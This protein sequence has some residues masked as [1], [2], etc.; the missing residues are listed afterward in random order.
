MVYELSRTPH[1][2]QAV[3]DEIDAI[4]GV[5]VARDPSAICERL[6]S[7][8]GGECISQMIYV[9]AVIKETLRLHPPAGT[10]RMASRGEGL[11]VSTSQG[12]YN[13]DG[14]SVYLNQSMIHRD[15]HVYGDDADEFIPQRWLKSNNLPPSAW[16]PFETGPRNCIGLELVNIEARLVVALIAHRYTFEKVGLGELQLDN[17][18]KPMLNQKNQFMTRSEL[19][20]VRYLMLRFRLFTNVFLFLHRKFR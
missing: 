8:G 4:F 7:N 18:G 17:T 16:R 6:M 12:D 2:L 19:Y 5:N 13:L 15:K 9:S 1:V 14:N 11:V 20:S 3:R 10:I